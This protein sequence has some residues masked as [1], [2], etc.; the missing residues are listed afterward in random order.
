MLEQNPYLEILSRLRENSQDSSTTTSSQSKTLEECGLDNFDCPLCGNTGNVLYQKDGMWYGRECE[1]MNTR[2]SLRRITTSGMS[3]L[4]ERY[5]FENYKTP[6]D[7]RRGIK[8]KAEEY[9]DGEGWMYFQGKPGSGKTHICTAICNRLMQKGKNVYYMAWRDESRKLK[10]L[11]NSEEIDEPLNRLKRIAVLY[12][13]DFMKGS[14]TEAD[15]RLAFEIIN[16]R[17]NDSKLRT[18]ISSEYSIEKILELDEAL[19]S[20]IYERSKGYI[21]TAPDENWRL[22]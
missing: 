17:Y 4:L 1:C 8:A 15:I 11:V 18:I 16:A 20:R 19:G 3:D 9:C 14:Q 10:G 22:R 2:R 6:D 21:M 5:T 7:K 13:D 12:I